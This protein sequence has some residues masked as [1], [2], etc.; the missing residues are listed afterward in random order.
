MDTTIRVTML[1]KFTIYGPGLVRPRV[2]SLSG[3]SKRLWTLVAYLILHRDRGVPAEE[4]ID[5]FWHE[6][7]GVNPM[8]TLQNNISRARN[9]LEELG[10][11]DGKRLI[12]NNSGTYFWAPTQK[13]LLDCEEFDAKAR[14]AMNCGDR[15]QAIGLAQE[16]A[17]LYTGDFLPENSNEGWCMGVGPTYRSQ[18]MTLCRTAVEWLMEEKRYEEAARMC[19]SVIAL[20]PVA[21]DFSVLYMRALTRGGKPE[22]ALSHYEKIRSYFR[23]A[24]GA[25]PTAR[26]EAER[27]EA[28]KSQSGGVEPGQVVRFLKTESHQEGAFQCDNNVFREIVNRHLRDMRRSGIPAQILVI[29]LSGEG[30]PQEK[31]SCIC[32]RWKVCCSILFGRE[33]PLPARAWSCFWPFCRVLP[34]TTERRWKTGSWEDTIRTTRRVRG[35]SI[36]RSWTWAIWARNGK[37]ESGRIGP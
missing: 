36:F 15:E 31:R 24:F 3:R 26:L 17:K 6:S 10:L 22:L 34:G 20:E 25:S 23:E 37:A 16:A 12:F 21:E 8:S 4:L 27:L 9:A 29:Q 5:L 33:T 2:I 1:G 19:D 32:A 14:E 30:L 18:Y 35:V 28:Q 11:E 13:T 7:E